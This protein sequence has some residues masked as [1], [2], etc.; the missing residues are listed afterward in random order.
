VT[1]PQT[2]F[3]A[4]QQVRSLLLAF[5][6]TAQARF[7]V[8]VQHCLLVVHGA[9]AARGLHFLHF[10]FFF[11]GVRLGGYRREAGYRD[12]R[13]CGPTERRSACDAPGAGRTDQ[14]REG[15]KRQAVHS[16]LR[17]SW[18]RSPTDVTN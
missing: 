11:L 18:D 1:P 15:V 16:V 9:S 12:C 4:P 8:F 7:V 13:G 10:F 5:S 17:I 2:A 3:S 14:P 6:A